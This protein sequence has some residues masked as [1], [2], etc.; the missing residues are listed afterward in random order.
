MKYIL[1]FVISITASLKS[2]SQDSSKIVVSIPMA[3]KDVKFI[4]CFVYN[5]DETYGNLRDSINVKYRAVS[6]PAEN[7]TSSLSAEIGTWLNLLQFLRINADAIKSNTFKRIDDALKLLVTQTYLITEI[8]KQDAAD[9]SNL[10]TIKQLGK[11]KIKR[12]NQ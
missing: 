5:N 4:S 2:F 9:V 3:Y 11:F 12:S 1:L 7:T 10:Q 6:E 8:G